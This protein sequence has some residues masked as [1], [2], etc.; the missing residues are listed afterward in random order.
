MN[1]RLMLG[2][3]CAVKKQHIITD[4]LSAAKRF[5]LHVINAFNE[6]NFIIYISLAYCITHY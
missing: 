5:A 1:V 2:L 3:D 4:I 6:G